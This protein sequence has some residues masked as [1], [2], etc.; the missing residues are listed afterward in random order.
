MFRSPG[1]NNDILI[2]LEKGREAPIVNLLADVG[3]IMEK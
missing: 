2:S 1:D 3:P